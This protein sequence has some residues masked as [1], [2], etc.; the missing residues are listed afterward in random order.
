[1]S[2]NIFDF[3]LQLNGFPILKAKQL[4]QQIQKK[5]DIEFKAYIKQQ[6]ERIITYHLA[7]NPFYKSFANGADVLNWNSIPV[8]TKR[9]LQQPLH[10]RLSDNF[11]EKTVYINK[12]SGSSGDPF[13]FA[14]D[15]FCHAMTWAEIQDRFSWYH[16]DFNRSKQVR[17]YGIP[18]NKKGYYKERIKDY[19]SNRYRFSIFDLSD[20]AF[21]RC[22][23]KFS[24]SKFDY[25]N[26]YTSAIVQ[27]AKFLQKKNIILKQICPTLKVCIVTA[28]MLFD[29]DKTLL[30]TQFGVPV[31][32]EYGASELDLIAFQN[33][34]NQWQLNSETLFVEILDNAN[35]LLPHGKEGR[36]VITSL[37]NKAHPF[38]RYDIGD[39]GVISKESTLRKPILEK[40]V[41]RTS[42]IV[43]LP[44]GKKAAGLTFYY[45]TKSIIENDGNV[46]EF[47][48]E[49]FKR[50]TFKIIYVS[51]EQL[52]EE[53]TK[54]ISN[55]MERYLEK[56]LVIN[57]ERQHT[58]QR[59]KSGKLKQFSS[60]LNKNP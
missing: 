50:E 56:G 19:F 33:T 15:K 27:F 6:K 21:D 26:G 8:M 39:I 59:L 16:L 47:V 36:I 12:T 52:S 10:K 5:S 45:I 60:L 32:N 9:D 14:K 48:I 4:L 41:G 17:F 38:I 35:N 42:D 58:L 30:E 34:N 28:E 23:Q 3:S 51:D 37:Y 44:S 46:K 53:N 18:L 1:M 24:V 29:D 55:A 22:V 7:N 31:I 43:V 2:L 40:L 54:A 25:V 57:F 49:Q 20:L 11:P 13:I